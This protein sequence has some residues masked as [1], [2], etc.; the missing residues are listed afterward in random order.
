MNGRRGKKSAVWQARHSEAMRLRG[1]GVLV[2]AAYG[3][4][5]AS[6]SRKQHDHA[7]NRRVRQK[8]TVE[9]A[10]SR[11]VP[12]GAGKSRPRKAAVG[13]RY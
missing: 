10:Y 4:K 8:A 9:A 13:F 2:P 12:S 3:Y 7:S 5:S 6:K 11:G 1:C